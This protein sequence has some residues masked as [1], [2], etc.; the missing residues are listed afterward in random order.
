MSPINLTNLALILTDSQQGA[1]SFPT[2]EEFLEKIIPNVW[3]FG[4]QLAALIVMI[5]V[6]FIFG[7]KPVRKI[8]SKR[9]EHIE[10][11]ITSAQKL[12]EDAMVNF[13]DSEVKLMETRKTADDMIENAK[14]QASIEK[15]AIIDKTNAEISKMKKDAETDIA[16]K[17]LQAQED[18][19]K[20][21][22]NV[23][24]LASSEL[25]KRETNTKDNERLVQDF[26]NDMDKE[27]GNN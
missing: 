4:I 24:L 17:K 23:A 16:R 15:Q 13:K 3:A 26:I 8:I 11:E 5:I 10:N 7:Y 6:F 1:H 20:E 12:N 18:V 27:D 2:P 19:K 22:V 9:Q 14:K 25:L 21:I